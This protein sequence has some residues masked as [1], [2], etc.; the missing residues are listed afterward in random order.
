MFLPSNITLQF[1]DSGDFV[2]ELQ[3]RLAM[4]RCFNEAMINGFYD[5]PTVNGVTL[6][7]SQC[8]LRADGI[9]GPETLR[10]L[11][12]SISGDTSSGSGSSDTK[13]EEE[14]AFYGQPQ[15]LLN[16]EILA[17]NQ[18][19]EQ[20]AWNTPSAPEIAPAPAYAPPP[21]EM[22]PAPSPYAAPDAASQ[23]MAANQ[24][25]LN[26]ET[27]ATQQQPQQYQPVPPP[28]PMPQ[29]GSDALAMFVN[30]APQPPQ[31][32]PVL[33]ESPARI[34]PP[35]QPIAYAAAPVPPQ[36]QPAPQPPTQQIP[37]TEAAPQQAPNLLQRTISAASGLIQ[38]LANYFEAKLPP[39][40][41]REVQ[42]IGQT[43]A[44]SGV[45]ETPI[46]ADPT[47]ARAPEQ[48]ARG[49]AQQQ[50]QQR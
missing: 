19:I 48:P 26:A 15:Q 12:S 7:Q 25:F 21:V 1:G 22:A 13:K 27:I 10:R 44:R 9:A 23:Q 24:Q 18:E 4:V 29:Q 38:K 41:L 28:Q 8:G 36:P 11:N 20:A 40:T 17:H 16:A 33:Q 49:P 39:D 3:R 32:Q 34:P 50:T 43:M 37:V 47:T 35:P 45:Q 6:F 2:S 14:Q 30:A 42:A 5:G 46:P 31:P